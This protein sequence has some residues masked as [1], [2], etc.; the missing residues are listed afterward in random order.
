[1]VKPVPALVATLVL[2]ALPSPAFG[3]DVVVLDDQGVGIS[4][5]D[6]DLTVHLGGKLN[7]DAL[8]VD[9]AT[10]SSS[11]AQ[12]RRA[13]VNVRIDYKDIATVR[14]EREF[15]GSRGWRNLYAQVRPAKGVQL[16]AGQFNVPFSLEDMQS[17]NIIPF[18]ERSL[19][20]GLTS[21]FAVGAQ[22]GYSAKR[23]TMR[24]GWFGNAMDTP[25]GRAPALGRGAV[26]R[27]TVLAVD[28]AR[29]KLHFGV[30]LERRSFGANDT[31]RYVADS[32]STFGP[33]ILRTPQLGNIDR[34][35]GYNAEV[36]F[37]SRNLALQ[38]QYI[39]QHIRQTTGRNRRLSGGYAQVSWVPTG[40]PYRY[41]RSAGIL[42]GPDLGRKKTAL[43]LAARV[44]WLDAENASIDGGIARSVDVSAGLY[45]GRNFRLL[46]SGTQSRFRERIG[47]P[48]EHVYVAVTR[49]QIA[50]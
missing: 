43:E 8:A 5:L 49:A 31:I 26:G 47:G 12:V 41:S 20:A 30:G 14:V 1:M 22:A 24:A 33:R 25:T 17:T 35:T 48:V 15:A 29:T 11:D 23:F 28:R 7:L 10:G 32:G 34:R 39:E 3:Q 37:F 16:Q 18:P 21:E 27:A 36:A 4:A 2:P 19:A 44:S 45:L 42:T 40:Q 46:V 6:R 13:R 9:G 50:F 38:G